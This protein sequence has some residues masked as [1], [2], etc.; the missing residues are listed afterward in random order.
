MS[1]KLR[2]GVIFGGRSGEHEVSLRSAESVINALDRNKY[3]VVP[4]AITRQGKWLASSEATNLLPSSVIETADQ[5]VAIFGDPT[6]RGL[7]RFGREGE[8]GGKRER[9]DVIIP[10]LHGTYG[11][12]GTIQGLLEMADVPYVG[13]GV[14]ASAT[15]MDKVIMKRLFHEAGLPIVDYL[16]F[17][18]NQWESEPQQI[19][20]RITAEIGFPCFV[21][22]ANL[23][24][25]VG[26]SKADDAAELKAAIALAAKYDRKVIVER[27]V[28]AREIEV[29]VLGNDEPAASVPGEIA[30]A[31]AEFYD[32]KA[33]YIDPNGARLLIPAP[34]DERTSAKTQQLAVRAFQAVDGSGLAR[35]D[36]FLEHETGRVLVNEINTMPGFTSISMYPKLWEASGIPYSQLINRLIELA[37]ERHRE[38]SRNVTSYG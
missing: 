12:D 2:V 6:E 22:P 14:L 1:G 4:I 38:K 18:R 36:F 7:A 3:E 31:T 32:Y 37:L 34:L 10:V 11:E 30:P 21:K 25:S 23:G 28:T 13:C 20:D 33:K 24:S 35:V 29:S 9:L 15:G 8:A 26:I 5:S 27:G 17:L 16:W 19:E